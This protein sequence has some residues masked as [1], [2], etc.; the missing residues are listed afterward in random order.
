MPHRLMVQD[1]EVASAILVDANV[2]RGELVGQPTHAGKA[3]GWIGEQGIADG[4]LARRAGD[5]LAAARHHADR[6]GAQRLDRRPRI[7]KG[8][9]GEVAVGAPAAAEQGQH[10]RA[11][12]QQLAR[13][14]EATCAVFQGE[15]GQGVAHRQA[16]LGHPHH[17]Q[18]VELVLDISPLARRERRRVPAA[19]LEQRL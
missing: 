3:V 5:D 18:P 13:G 8:Q 2:R 11:T 17:A 16:V 7:L 4:A 1:A 6:R 14:P 19:E 12:I 9:H 15:I 10:Q